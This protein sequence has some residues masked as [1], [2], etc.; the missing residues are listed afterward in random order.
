MQQISIEDQKTHAILIQMLQDEAR[1]GSQALAKGGTAFPQ[2][3]K[4]A[5]SYLAKAMTTTTYYI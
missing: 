4:E 1:H 2:V 5:M 3:I